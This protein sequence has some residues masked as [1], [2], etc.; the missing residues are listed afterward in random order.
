MNSV[1]FYLFKI[2]KFTIY[3]VAFRH[4]LIFSGKEFLFSGIQGGIV[5]VQKGGC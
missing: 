3:W 4:H 1:K 2:K 5:N